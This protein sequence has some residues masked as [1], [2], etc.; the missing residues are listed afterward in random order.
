MGSFKTKVIESECWVDKLPSTTV[1]Q[2]ILH[3]GVINDDSEL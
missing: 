2:Y 1:I 3:N